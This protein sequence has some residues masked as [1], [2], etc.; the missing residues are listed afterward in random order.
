MFQES[1]IEK[2]NDVLKKRVALEGELAQTR[3]QLETKLAKTRSKNKAYLFL[4]LVLPLLAFW[5]SKKQYIAP[6]EQKT[7][8]QRDSIARLHSEIAGA[9][10]IK[11]DS[12]HYVIKKGDMLVA[13]GKLFFNDPAMGYQIGIDNGI[14]SEQQRYNLIPGDTLT[15]HYR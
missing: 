12:I 14:T 2:Y 13:L 15:I 11:K 1:L 3:H 7:V 6:L 5:W 8:A 10:K 9:K 4:L